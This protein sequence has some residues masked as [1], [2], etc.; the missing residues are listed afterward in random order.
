MKE[1]FTSR[2]I[3]KVQGQELFKTPPPNL[4]HRH[5]PI[6]IEK[7]IVALMERFSLTRL[8]ARKP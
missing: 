5:D 7:A 1:F 8:E 3:W 4:V 6:E 2:L